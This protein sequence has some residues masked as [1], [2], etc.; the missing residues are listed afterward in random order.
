MRDISISWPSI[1]NSD[2]LLKRLQQCFL[3]NPLTYNH[4]LFA[5]R[6][7]FKASASIRN[8]LY[9]PSP[10][11]LLFW[12]DPCSRNRPCGKLGS[13]WVSVAPAAQ[14]ALEYRTDKTTFLFLLWTKEKQMKQQISYNP[15]KMGFLGFHPLYSLY[16]VEREEMQ[17][18][19]CFFSIQPESTA[20]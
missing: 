5:A 2:L 19:Q 13:P 14:S 4:E 15:E 10:N 20:T 18:S 11:A 6:D 7:H 9:M 12:G 1:Q 16:S 3:C 8:K 17:T